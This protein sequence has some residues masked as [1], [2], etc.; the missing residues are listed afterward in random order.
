MREEIRSLIDKQLPDYI[1]LQEIIQATKDDKELQELIKCISGRRKLGDNMA[2]YRSIMDDLWI[3]DDGIVLR[4]DTIVLPK[5]LQ[6]RAIKHVHGGHLGIVLSKRL[7]KSRTWFMGADS[8]MEKEVHDCLPCQANSD[9]TEHAPLIIQE[10]QKDNL[11]LVSLD[12]SSRTPSND[13]LLVAIYERSR[14]PAYSIS[15]NLTGAQAV[16]HSKRIFEKHGIPQEVKTDNGPAFRSRE[17]NE[18]LRRLG[19][20]HTKITPLNP[21]ANGSCERLMRPINKCI[22]CARVDG[23]SWKPVL[24][25]W[26]ESY[27]ATPHSSTGVTPEAAKGIESKFNKLPQPANQLDHEATQRTLEANTRVSRS[28][29]KFYADNAQ[30][31]KQVTFKEGDK[32]MYKW[33]RSNKH[34]SIFNPDAYV[35]SKVNA[36]SI[37]LTPV[38]RARE[39][40]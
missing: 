15:K 9:T 6:S 23:T 39:Q 18:F 36:T 17:F 19:I 13:Y 30:N 24:D 22:R 32:V 12:F 40:N 4:G 8:A 35:V 14:Y 31:A 28:K 11:S 27:R 7:L 26:I 38:N 5:S 29:Q 16:I 1:S 3:S 20:K 10:I 33:P 37:K 25:K 34:E 2:K 21:E